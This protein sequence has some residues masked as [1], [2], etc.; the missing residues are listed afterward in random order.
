MKIFENL[1]LSQFLQNPK[2]VSLREVIL[3]EP[4][5]MDFLSKK[6]A[7]L[8]QIVHHHGKNPAEPLQMP[9]RSTLSRPIWHVV[10]FVAAVEQLM[11]WLRRTLSRVMDGLGP[12]KWIF[13]GKKSGWLA[14]IVR[15]SGRNPAE[16]LQMPRRSTRSQPIWHVVS[17][18]APAEQIKWFLSQSSSLKAQCTH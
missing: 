3:P 17:F 18:G 6:K 4:K 15:Y 11:R 12:K 7:L 5:K 2:S 8:A 10:S 14:R 13:L 1:D 16:P 9:R